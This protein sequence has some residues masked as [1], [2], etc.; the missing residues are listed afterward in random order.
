MVKINKEKI[1]ALEADR[2]LHAARLKE[3][4]AEIANEKAP[5][6]MYLKRRKDMF[7]SGGLT[8]NRLHNATHFANSCVNK[9]VTEEEYDEWQGV[10]DRIENIVK[11]LEK[12]ILPKYK[13]EKAQAK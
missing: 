12:N 9:A 4:E 11:D 6:E 1:A 10:L 8:L 13:P 2:E 5:E 7:D 3:I